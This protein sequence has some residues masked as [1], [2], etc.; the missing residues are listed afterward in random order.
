MNTVIP[1]LYLDWEFPF[2]KNFEIELAKLILSGIELYYSHSKNIDESNVNVKGDESKHIIQ[3]MRHQIDDEI[4]IT[5]GAG[6]IYKCRINK[7][8][9]QE[10]V[11]QVIEEYNFEQKLRNITFCIPTLRSNDR[12]EFAIEKAAEL[13]I[14]NFI[15]YRAKRSVN[16]KV[17]LTRLEKILVSAMK[18]SLQS[19]V[20]VIR[21]IDSFDK[22][23]SAES[24][25]IIFDQ[26]GGQYFSSNKLAMNSNYYLIFGP[27][28]DF[29]EEETRRM[30]EVKKY[31]LAEN[32]LRTETAVIKA[33]SLF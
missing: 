19:W 26:T 32:R 7:I 17:N 24:E 4:F 31:K 20:P 23:I 16:K 28:G 12:L 11:T 6:K 21:F 33:A 10:V 8:S 5:N 29:S 30:K 3:V 2:N 15:I 13:G 9:K 1:N 18:Q 27:E 14:T 22:L 25:K